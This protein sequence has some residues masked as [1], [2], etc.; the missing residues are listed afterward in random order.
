MIDLSKIDKI[1]E[2]KGNTK[3]S[4]IPILQAIQKEYNYLPEEVLRRVSE[5]TSIKPAEIIGVASFYSQF[6]LAPVGDHMIRVCIGTACHVKGAGQVYDA[7]RREFK[8]KAGQYTDDKGKYTLEQ[9]SCLG[10]CTLAPVVQIDHITYGHVTSDKIPEILKDFESQKAN[11]NQKQ[12]RNPDGTEIKGEIR[13]GLG[14]CCVAS[15]SEEIRQSVEQMLDKND[16][17]VNL[18]SVGCVGMC[19][20]VPLM[21]IVPVNGEATLYAKV[22]PEEVKNIIE[23]HFQPVGVFTRLKNKFLKTV[24]KIK[25][26]SN[27]EGIEAY[28]L[29]IS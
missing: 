20:Q 17:H 27:W 6:R 1:V 23:K 5:I 11:N 14:S 4:L 15:G 9:V 2:E 12:F 3:R 10:C 25:A 21:E 24:E 18:K 26:D 8:L 29:D 28:K 7:I 22:K 16:L 19:H 13:I